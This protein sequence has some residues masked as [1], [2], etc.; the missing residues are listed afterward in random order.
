MDEA[1]G[2]IAESLRSGERKHL[3]FEEA[4]Y[5]GCKVGFTPQELYRMTSYE[6]NIA[7][8][9]RQYQHEIDI[10]RQA[11]WSVRLE[12]EW[13]SESGLKALADYLPATERK[14]APSQPDAI[15]KARRMKQPV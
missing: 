15:A 14:I 7:V 12:A 13:K 11:W 1:E 9:A 3:T 4:L 6:R 8:A 2:D 5:E 10:V